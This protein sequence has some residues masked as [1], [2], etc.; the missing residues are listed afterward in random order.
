MGENGRNQYSFNGSFTLEIALLMPFLLLTLLLSVYLSF[1]IYDILLITQSTYIAA[2]RGSRELNQD[3]D[4]VYQ[5]TKEEL[6]KLLDNQLLAF[7]GREDKITV[8]YGE[9]EVQVEGTINIPFRIV[10]GSRGKAE[11]WTINIKNTVNRL[12]PEDFIRNVRRM[13]NII[14]KEQ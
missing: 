13:E 1:Y 12:K 10:S 5:K 7:A 2:Y 11:G 8:R 14:N 9:I 3:N 4:V 6:K